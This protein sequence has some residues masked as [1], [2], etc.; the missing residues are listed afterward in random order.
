MSKAIA[1]TRT[2]YEAAQLGRIELARA[3]LVLGC[4]LALVLAGQPLP[5]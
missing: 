5:L 1:L 2:A 4:G 3:S